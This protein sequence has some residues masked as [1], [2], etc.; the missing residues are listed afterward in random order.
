MDN[1]HPLEKQSRTY[2]FP[3]E[4]AASGTPGDGGGALNRNADTA[5]PSGDAEHLNDCCGCRRQ[6][7]GQRKARVDRASVSLDSRLAATRRPE[8]ARP[9]AIDEATV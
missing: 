2:G 6:D 4:L 8:D 5:R 7:Q 9:E 1:T 3:N